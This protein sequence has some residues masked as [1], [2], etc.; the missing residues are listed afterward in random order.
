MFNKF[1]KIPDS[2]LFEKVILMNKTTKNILNYKS[3]IDPHEKAY[4]QSSKNK[5]IVVLYF[6]MKLFLGDE[7]KVLQFCGRL[8]DNNTFPIDCTE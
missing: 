7:G 4:E 1:M 5:V 8:L 3:L 2:C 6:C